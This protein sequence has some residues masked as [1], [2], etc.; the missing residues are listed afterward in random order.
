MIQTGVYLS[1]TR[2][3]IRVVTEDRIGILPEFKLLKYRENLLILHNPDQE[4]IL[5]KRHDF[6]GSLELLDW[7]E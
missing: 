4:N 2:G 7:R 5:R 6:I 1:K 3:I